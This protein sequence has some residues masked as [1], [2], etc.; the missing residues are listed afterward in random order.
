MEAENNF[1][2]KLEI[3]LEQHRESLDN[4]ELP[5]LKETIRL[6]TSAFEGIYNLLLKKGLISEDPYKYEQKISEITPPPADQIL[7]SEKINKISQRLSMYDSQ[8]DFL[9]SYYEFSADFITMPRIKK[10]NLLIN[11]I[12][13][14]NLSETSAGINTKIMAE[15]VGKIT[16][17]SDQMSINLINDSLKRMNELSKKVVIAARVISQYQREKYKFDIRSSIITQ[18]GISAADMQSKPE[19]TLISSE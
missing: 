11:W 3:V 1:L 14:S 9:N 16:Q 18:L 2:T 6:F 10:L 19:D 4:K 17:G 7:E 12:K 8:L 5:S 13:W 15:I